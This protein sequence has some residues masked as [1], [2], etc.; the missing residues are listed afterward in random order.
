M[1]GNASERVADW[2][3]RSTACRT[4][5][6]GVSPTGD[7]QCLAGADTVNERGALLRGGIRAGTSAGPLAVDGS[8][9]PPLS[10]FVGFRCAR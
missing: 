6:A 2:E 4:W 9:M 10:G 8:F 3:S 5:S 7:S 1:V